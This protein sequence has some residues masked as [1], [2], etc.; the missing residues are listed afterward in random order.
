MAALLS[1]NGLT[2]R[3]AD[4]KGRET[5][6]VDAVTFDVQPGRTIA[7][8]GESGSGKTTVSRACMGYARPGC[9]IAGG[10]VAL[11]GRAVLDLPLPALQELRG[12]QITYVAQ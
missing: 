12:R 10:S 5:T 7:L 9:R 2:V 3:A 8:I 1:V 6:I 4:R 11:D